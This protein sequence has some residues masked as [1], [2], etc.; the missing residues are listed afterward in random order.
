LVEK[1]VEKEEGMALIPDVTV[2]V[3]DSL[4]DTPITPIVHGVLG[5]ERRDRSLEGGRTRSHS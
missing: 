1:L 4:P 5:V 2:P 3:L